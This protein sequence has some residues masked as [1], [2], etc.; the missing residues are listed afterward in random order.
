MKPKTLVSLNVSH[1]QFQETNDTV[2][3]SSWIWSMELLISYGVGGIINWYVRGYKFIKCL[4]CESSKLYGLAVTVLLLL[5]HFIFGKY[6]FLLESTISRLRFESWLIVKKLIVW[7]KKFGVWNR[8]DDLVTQC[9]L[10]SNYCYRIK[11]Y[12]SCN[13]YNQNWRSTLSLP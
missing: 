8:L 1:C 13:V 4:S 6:I 12:V 5:S 3:R 10:T 7:E 11:Y 9:R 2:S